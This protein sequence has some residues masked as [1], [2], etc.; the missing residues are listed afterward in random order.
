MKQAIQLIILLLVPLS[1]LSQKAIKGNLFDTSSKEAVSYA[2]VFYKNQQQIGTMSQS[3]GSFVLR[4]IESA[5]TDTLVVS[6]LGYKTEFYPV[7]MIT[8]TPLQIAM[9]LE[10]IRL[11][12]ISIVSDDALR[13][14]LRKV[15]EHI[16]QNYPSEKHKLIGYYQEYSA[17][18]DEYKHYLDAYISVENQ[19]YK[20]D[21]PLVVHPNT[22][23]KLPRPYH[24]VYA[25]QLR[26]SDDSRLLPAHIEKVSDTPIHGFLRGNKMYTKSFSFL[27]LNHSLKD[28]LFDVNAMNTTSTPKAQFAVPKIIGLGEQYQDK[29]TLVRIALMEIPIRDLETGIIKH[30]LIQNE[31]L[32]NKSNYAVEQMT[33][34]GSQEFNDKAKSTGQRPLERFYEVRYRNINGT[35]YPS[36]ISSDVGFMYMMQTQHDFVS[37]RFIV[38][39][40]EV[41]KKQY[42]KRKPR[43]KV[44][45][46]TS[47]KDLKLQYDPEF[48]ESFQI[49][50]KLEASVM[51]KA[52]LSRTTSLEEQ[53]KKN[54]RKIN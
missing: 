25:H 48:W 21:H 12:E 11:N 20:K 33:S 26:R 52:A 29:D 32:I 51:I 6:M 36:M 45:N 8:D 41:T 43:K 24:K 53:F 49:P 2:N 30:Y 34:M 13:E 44:P 3:D 35:Y 47:I 16:P 37:R 50:P 46:F 22:G 7:K 9:E 19:S 42:Q 39:E 54:Q 40:T 1:L 31:L 5:M 14:L 28:L 18:F 27:S 15:V 17:S 38:L 23:S 10:A 4:R